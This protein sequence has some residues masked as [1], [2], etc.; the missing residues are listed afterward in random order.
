MTNLS[1]HILNILLFILPFPKCQPFRTWCQPFSESQAFFAQYRAIQTKIDFK[2]LFIHYLDHVWFLDPVSLHTYSSVSPFTPASSDRQAFFVSNWD[3]K[4]SRLKCKS[5]IQRGVG[6]AFFPLLLSLLFSLFQESLVDFGFQKSRI[7]VVFHQTIYQS[8]R[9][10][11]AIW[12]RLRDIFTDFFSRHTVNVYLCSGNSNIYF[13]H[14]FFLFGDI[15]ILS[16]LFRKL[17]MFK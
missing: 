1:A 17:T 3:S 9:P 12:P 6:R 13:T 7:T 4:E 8:L 5:I 15:F 11:E 16:C 14:E 10:V 2:S